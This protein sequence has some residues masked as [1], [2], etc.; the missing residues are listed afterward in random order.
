[1]E[2]G[3]HQNSVDILKVGDF[4]E[5]IKLGVV[6][7][8]FI[9]RVSH[10]HCVFEFGKL[11]KLVKFIPTLDFVIY[12]SNYGITANEKSSQLHAHGQTLQLFYEVVAKPEFFKSPCHFLQPR[13]F[14]YVVPGKREPG[15][16]FERGEV[17]NFIDVV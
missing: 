14:L 4:F 7:Q 17:D 5:S 13:Y 16:I 15:E 3:I 11:F 1:M 6:L 10:Q 8:N 9:E 12:V 2:F